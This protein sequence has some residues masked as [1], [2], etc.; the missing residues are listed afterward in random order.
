G[1]VVE[2]DEDE[3]LPGFDTNRDQSVLRAVE[4]LHPL[5][6]GHAFQ[7]AVESVI[8]AVIRTMQERSLAAGFGYDG[9]GVMAAN[10][11][12][13]AQNAVV[14]ADKDYRLPGDNIAYKL[15]RRFQLLRAGDQ[16][17]G[18]AEHAQA[19]EVRYAGINVPGRRDR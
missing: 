10:I 18:F 8:P 12:E 4:I 5:E 9:S 3:A 19:F 7:R 15:A 1:V 14:A 17:P 13:R 16:L 6:L 2:I 11:V